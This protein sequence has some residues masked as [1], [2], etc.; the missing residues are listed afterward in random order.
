MRLK[1]LSQLTLMLVTGLLPTSGLLI[2][3]NRN[4]AAESTGSN[5]IVLPA[6]GLGFQI[7]LS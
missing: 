2:L 6:C 4:M 3:F 5:V 7:P 1:L